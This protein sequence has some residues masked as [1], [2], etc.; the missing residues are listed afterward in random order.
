MR[1]TELTI[2]KFVL[3]RKRRNN[4]SNLIWTSFSNAVFKTCNSFKKWGNDSNSGCECYEHLMLKNGSL[5]QESLKGF[6]HLLLN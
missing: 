2:R 1:I 5:G 4:N 3:L 6:L